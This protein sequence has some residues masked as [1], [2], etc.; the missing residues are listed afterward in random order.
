MLEENANN[1]SI[2]EKQLLSIVR[3]IIKNPKINDTKILINFNKNL[4]K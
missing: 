4:F 1:L 3:C 2:G